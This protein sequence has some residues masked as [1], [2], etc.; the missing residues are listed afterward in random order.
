MQQ[1]IYAV[2]DMYFVVCSCSIFGPLRVVVIKVNLSPEHIEAVNF[3]ENVQ[4][5]NIG[6]VSEAVY[7]G[8]FGGNAWVIADISD[9]LSGNG[10]WV[11]VSQSVPSHVDF[12]GRVLTIDRGWMVWEEGAIPANCG[13]LNVDLVENR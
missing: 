12:V 2:A 8:P 13:E 11:D 10:D 5:S 9:V 3:V 7:F 1:R 6:V 4:T